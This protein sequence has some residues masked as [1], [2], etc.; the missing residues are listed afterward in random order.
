MSSEVFKSSSAIST[1]SSCCT[2]LS[3]SGISMSLTKSSEILSKAKSAL[4]LIS[5]SN[6]ALQSSLSPISDCSASGAIAQS[7]DVPKALSIDVGEIIS[8]ASLV[9]ASQIKSSI[10]SLT[11]ISLVCPQSSV[12]TSLFEL[13]LTSVVGLG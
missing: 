4:L 9:G 1:I 13:A 2:T 3:V 10:A 6:P 11:M 5:S 12:T 8:R 7:S